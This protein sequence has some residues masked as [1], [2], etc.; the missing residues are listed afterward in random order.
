MYWLLI[1]IPGADVLDAMGAVAPLVFFC[2]ALAIV[3]LAAL[4]AAES[5][6]AITMARR[7]KMDLSVGIAMGSSIQ[8]AL[9]VTPVLVLSSRLLGPEPLTLAFTRV[10]IGSLFFGVLI[11]ALIAGDGRANWY[12]GMQLLAFY[13]IL[14]AMFYPIPAE[15]TPVSGRSP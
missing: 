12:K 6:A 2:A 8:I 11:G 4:S 10:E 5:G 14:A 7:N 13:L 9:F 15:L 1:I 3:P